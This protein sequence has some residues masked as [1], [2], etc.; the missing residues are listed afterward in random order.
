MTG[1]L[2]DLLVGD[3]WRYT[4]SVLGAL[5]VAVGVG[6][7]LLDGQLTGEE[8]TQISSLVV[9]CLVLI[10]LGSRIAV[11]IR[12]PSRMVRVLGW[13]SVGVLS[14]ATL[15]VWYQVVVQRTAETTFEMALLFLSVLA[16]GALFGTVVGYYDVRVRSLVERASREQARREFLDHQQESLSSL[17]RIL[18]HQI[19]NDLSAISG[20]AE[21]LAADRIDSKAATDSI[22]AHC[23]HME[24]TVDR[25]D[26]LL[27]V[28]TH[29]DA[30]SDVPV[31]DAVARAY[32]TA[33]E[34]HPDLAVEIDAIEDVTV[35]A[36]ELLSLAIAE[37]LKNAAEH[38]DGTI[39]VSVH[40]TVDTAVVDVSDEGSG[41]DVTPR[42]SLFEPN[43]RGP[44]SDGDGLGLF[45]SALVVDRYDG[46]IRPVETD[47]GTTFEIEIP[48]DGTPIERG[49]TTPELGVE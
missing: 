26:T 23:E 3:W 12:T 19:L 29:V 39:T 14:I 36:D 7:V 27:G 18:R 33:R 46:E 28:L 21:L 34:Y 42:E 41:I 44:E 35:R 49:R 2:R 40:E 38:G 11:E 31:A 47:D 5:M 45:L 22:L 1:G 24:E 10:G 8:V 9:I 48:T 25:L 30:T 20:R 17:N 6:S 15:G 13:M 43:T 16:S 37:L 32:E 4:I